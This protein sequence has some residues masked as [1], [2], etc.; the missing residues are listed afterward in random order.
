MQLVILLGGKASR[1]RLLAGSTPKSLVNVHGKPFLFHMLL[2]YKEMGFSDF[3]FLVRNDPIH[4]KQ[5][6]VLMKTLPNINYSLIEDKNLDGGTGRSLIDCIDIL[7]EKFW[8]V[9]GDSW[10]DNKET[11]SIKINN[12]F[13]GESFSIIFTAVP[14]VGDSAN[15]IYL[16]ES[17][18]V[19]DY[20]KTGFI[21]ITGVSCNT[22]MKAIDFGLIFL[23]KKD[24]ELFV[25][26]NKKISLDMGDLYLWLI[27]KKLL[28]SV[29]ADSNYIDIG[30]YK[31]WSSLSTMLAYNK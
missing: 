29:S 15:L 7:K 13:L 24:V 11:L 6:R 16:K 28:R 8:V 25:K 21:N 17:N 5:F 19:I 27:R 26:S 20:K 4:I 18:K 14:N 31:G 10:F 30:T 23:I 22:K 12:I 2:I 1:L 3:I 9:N